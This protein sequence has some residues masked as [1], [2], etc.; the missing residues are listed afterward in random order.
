M[1][2]KKL[3]IAYPVN[4]ALS[5]LVN[6]CGFIFLLSMLLI[7]CEKSDTRQEQIISFDNIPPQN[8]IDGSIR[9]KA[10]VSS[11]LPVTFTSNDPRVATIEG[12]KLLFVKPGTLFVVA[13]QSG[14]NR[15]KEV[16]EVR[17][18]FIRDYDPNKKD[19]TVTFPLDVSEWKYTLG[20]LA[21]QA[22]AS[23][24]LPVTFSVDNTYISYINNTEFVLTPD[25][26]SSSQASEYV[27]ITASQNGNNEYNP[28][29]NISRKVKILPY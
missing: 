15:F 20:P 6:T 5:R 19:Q 4:F 12:D 10:T 22:T 11:G 7:A 17:E 27:T 2:K 3:S 25:C 28:A 23:S 24:D 29:P 16:Q 9:L 14:D 1:K 26:H 18:I 8:F 21:L 13:S